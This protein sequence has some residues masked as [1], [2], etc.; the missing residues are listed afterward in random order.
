MANEDYSITFKG[1]DEILA[2]FSVA[3]ERIEIA[4]LEAMKKS[5]LIVQA[6]SMAYVHRVTGQLQGST[7]SSVVGSGRDITGIVGSNK[8]YARAYQEGLPSGYPIN[9]SKGRRLPNGNQSKPYIARA[10]GKR[11]GLPYLKEGLQNNV[12]VIV[13]VFVEASH[14]IVRELAHGR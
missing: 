13:N 7:T 3:P 9:F 6:S 11:K 1:V 5:T 8:V 2:N 14:K 10:S 12:E 4:N